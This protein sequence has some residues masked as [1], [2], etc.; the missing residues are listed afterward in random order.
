MV[1]AAATGALRRAV[2]AWLGVLVVALNLIGATMLPAAAKPVDDASGWN[3]VCTASGIVVLGGSDHDGGAPSSAAA[4]S[5]L[6]QFCLPLLHAGLPAPVADPV[7]LPSRVAHV[8]GPL[9]SS[10]RGPGAVAKD[11]ASPRAPPRA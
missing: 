11:G 7:P 9:H 8:D 5:G 2:C 6:C 10:V 3:T 1:T 4:G